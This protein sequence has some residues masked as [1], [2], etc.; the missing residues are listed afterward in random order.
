M[1]KLEQFVRRFRRYKTPPPQITSPHGI[2]TEAARAQAAENMRLRPDVKLAVEKHLA[3]TKCAGDM[4]R[5]RA[6]SRRMYPEAYE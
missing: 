4:E 1:N 6:M 5:G 2:T 3:D